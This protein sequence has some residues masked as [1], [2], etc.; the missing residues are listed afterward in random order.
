M[1]QTEAAEQA[2]PV[3]PLDAL[4]SR[5]ERAPD[6]TALVAAG[7]RWSCDRLAAESARLAA[8]F[9]ARGVRPGDRVAL[10]M[11]NVPEA[12]LAYLACWRT[13][14]VAVPINVR[15][16]APELADVLR[17]ARPALFLGHAALH[18]AWAGVDEETMPSK[19]RVV[20]AGAS[21]GSLPWDALL[22]GAADGAGLDPLPTDL[23]APAVLL[24]TSGTTGRSKLVVWTPRNLAA[25]TA[26][27]T[28]RGA[29][30]DDVFLLA[31]PMMHSSGA[32]FTAACL[33]TGARS[34][35]LPR[36]DPDAVLDAVEEHRCTAF[37]GLPFMYGE[38]VRRQRAQPRDLGSLRICTAA[39]NVCPAGTE[40]A[41]EAVAG[42]P[43]LSLWASTEEPGATVPALRTGPLTRLAPGAEVRFADGAGRPAGDDGAG[44]MLIRSPTTTPG[45]WLGAGRIDPLPDGW[46]RSGDRMRRE[47]DG[48]LRYLGRIKETIV[49]GGS[50]VSPLEV[51]EV[52]RRQPG[53]A[54]AAV[55]G[56]PDPELGQR[57]GAMLVLAADA[58]ATAAADALAGVRR[59]LAD[60]KVP[61]VLAV[62]EAIPRNALTKV[63]RPAV[64]RSIIAAKA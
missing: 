9:R 41:F 47:P 33:L 16:K 35:L 30:A 53:I 39:G 1:Q 48:H 10:Q 43:L 29:G 8:S 27:A 15:F 44:E 20:V 40:R 12:V 37:F 58:S 26:S 2:S 3:T 49:R 34:V 18:E 21:P 31:A 50:N 55:A 19:A 62:V 28:D 57:I 7:Q 63:D 59:E 4:L 6:A 17:R 25:F 60:Y 38:V 56:L 11:Y 54:D 13:G 52:L 61:E 24:G 45:Y 51:E 42:R 22:D 64:S 36:F 23:D 14:A 5:A 32:F 46:L